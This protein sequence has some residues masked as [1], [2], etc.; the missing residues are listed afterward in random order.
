MF[1]ETFFLC[2]YLVSF[3]FILPSTYISII[4]FNEAKE[5][6]NI[7]IGYYLRKLIELLFAIE[8]YLTLDAK[9]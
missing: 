3:F 9:H 1:F 2:V 5:M 8:P 7:E 4:W 6:N